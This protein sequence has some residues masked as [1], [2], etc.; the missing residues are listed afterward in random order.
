MNKT[1]IVL[2]AYSGRINRYA[3]AKSSRILAATT[4]SLNLKIE[5]ISTPR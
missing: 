4:G 5:M 1:G 2:Y 3:E